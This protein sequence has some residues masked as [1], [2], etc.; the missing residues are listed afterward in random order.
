MMTL[1]TLAGARRFEEVRTSYREAE[2]AAVA[3]TADLLRELGRY[4]LATDLYRHL[5]ALGESSDLHY[6][7][8]ESFGKMYR[9]G[10]AL[11]HLERAFALAPARTAGSAYYAYILERGGRLAEAEHYYR[12]AL[13]ESPT[14]P[15][16][17]SHYAHYLHKCGDAEQAAQTYQQVLARYPAYTWAV[18]RYALLM[19]E[20]GEPLAA[21]ALMAQSTVGGNPFARLNYLE[22]LLLVGE[23]EAYRSFRAGIDATRLSTPCQ[24]IL[25]LFDYA[26]EVL[27][28]GASD[29]ERLTAWKAR[30]AN[31]DETIHR[32][33]DDLEARIAHRGGNLDEWRSLVDALVK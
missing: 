32:D 28:V 1:K 2:P 8:G 17:L 10:D 20:R 7:L 21:A 9:Y 4:R 26:R 16:V 25:E 29:P 13:A 27:L 14:D 3:E 31:L 5:L 19:L 33:F 6:G 12:R 18:K 24:V 30:V 15:W 23:E 22:Y 11:A